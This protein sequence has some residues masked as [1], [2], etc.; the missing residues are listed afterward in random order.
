MIVDI[1][2]HIL[3]GLDD[4]AEDIQKAIQMGM[5]AVENGITHI[6]ATPHH[7]N[8]E[9]VCHPEQINE[10]IA[11]LNFLFDRQDIPLTVLPGMEVHLY[12]SLADDMASTGGI[13]TLGESMKYVLVE[14]PYSH[15]PHFTGDI[16][17]QMQLKGF[18][19]VIAHPER[20]A[21]I[22]KRPNILVELIQKGA[23]AQITAAS[24][25]G[26]FGKE[27]QKLSIKLLK[28]N[29]VHFIAS[30]AHNVTN[31]SFQL[32]S[33]YKYIEKHF[34]SEYTDYL[35]ENA[36][37]VVKGKEFCIMAPQKFERKSKIFTFG[38]NR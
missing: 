16:F 24:I 23:L 17:Y 22:K 18:I 20:N 32:L 10:G 2:N 6:I 28:H 5:Q 36:S 8:G 30:D 31:R 11:I 9:Y 27:S 34:S 7:R 1:H 35:I 4:G 37:N 19:P 25:A 3:P 38:A 29:L 33:A 21:E 14:L 15:V 26:L 12:G 13:V